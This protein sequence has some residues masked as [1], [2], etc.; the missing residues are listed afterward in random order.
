MCSAKEIHSH[1]QFQLQFQLHSAGKLKCF[2]QI[3]S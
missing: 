1:F 2:E 3:Y